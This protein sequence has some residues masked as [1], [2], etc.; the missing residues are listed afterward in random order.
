MA[1]KVF[2][3]YIE[4]SVFLGVKDRGGGKNP[5]SVLVLLSGERERETTCERKRE[6]GE[7]GYWE[8]YAYVI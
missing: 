3:F 4:R 8:N 1:T 2:Y 6:N 7:G 5:K